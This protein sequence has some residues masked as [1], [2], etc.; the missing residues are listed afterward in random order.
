MVDITDQ[1]FL[2]NCLFK[3]T[4]VKTFRS[5]P[6]ILG[7]VNIVYQCVTG[8][9]SFRVPIICSSGF[10]LME[11]AVTLTGIFWHCSFRN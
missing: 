1:F 7:K 9:S 11:G 5:F 4:N 3:T 10:D 8:S 2:S 6:Y